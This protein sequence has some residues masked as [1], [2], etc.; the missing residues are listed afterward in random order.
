M[1]TKKDRCRICYSSDASPSNPL[2]SPCL[3]SGSLLF[4]HLDWLSFRAVQR[5]EICKGRVVVDP[6]VFDLKDCYMR[7]RQVN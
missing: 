6:N 4:I 1:D 7:I 2:L 5:C 3:C